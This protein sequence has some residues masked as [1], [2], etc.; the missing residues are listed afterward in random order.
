MFFSKKQYFRDTT[1]PAGI[2]ETLPFR[3]VPAPSGRF[4][5][6]RNPETL[7]IKNDYFGN[8]LL[9]IKDRNGVIRQISV[10]KGANKP[11]GIDGKVKWSMTPNKFRRG[12]GL[13]TDTSL[14]YQP[15]KRRDM[16][17]EFFKSRYQSAFEEALIEKKIRD[18]NKLGANKIKLLNDNNKKLQDRLDATLQSNKLAEDRLAQ[19]K[20]QHNQLLLAL[21]NTTTPSIIFSGDK[22][23][24][25]AGKIT[26]D[27]PLLELEDKKPE[28]EPAPE[29]SPEPAPEV[30][31]AQNTL[32]A[33][34]VAGLGE[35]DKKRAAAGLDKRY[36]SGGSEGGI[37]SGVGGLSMSP[38]AP[39]G[40]G[41]SVASTA[42]ESVLSSLTTAE[43]EK[44]VKKVDELESLSSGGTTP[45]KKLTKKQRKEIAELEKKIAN[46]PDKPEVFVAQG[47]KKVPNPLEPK[48]I[49]NPLIE[50]GGGIG[51]SFSALAEEIK[52]DESIKEFREKRQLHSIPE[53][54]T[55]MKES[56]FSNPVQLKFGEHAISAGHG[57]TGGM[58]KIMDFD[59]V[60]SR[61]EGVDT[62]KFKKT[63]HRN[64]AK[65]V[66]WRLD[67]Y[68]KLKDKPFMDVSLNK[69]GSFKSFTG[70]KKDGTFTEH[71][72]RANEITLP[73]TQE[74]ADAFGFDLEEHDRLHKETKDLGGSR[75]GRRKYKKGQIISYKGQSGKISK[76]LP[77]DPESEKLGV[78]DLQ[79]EL[80]DGRVVD[81]TDINL[82]ELD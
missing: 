28:P 45:R 3:N 50:G 31:P 5:N 25:D 52:E 4:I 82:D 80:D 22:G 81:T 77:P 44:I 61:F 64:D 53:L 16:T 6:V 71:P 65:K 75:A 39:K 29:V 13:K 54:H 27:K 69:D 60:K 76:V 41:A 8:E 56:K 15:P 9:T 79:I 32:G 58:G 73:P 59:D 20:L 34:I 55:K 62:S 35:Q 10:M 40:S 74:Y 1:L 72:L 49:K 48:P 66:E 12:R 18:S 17:T 36:V 63:K 21:S 43:A 7:S 14:F 26:G 51:S 19:D 33:A 37:T 46:D 42:E 2:T 70:K 57:K 67:N 23:A 11:R 68:D 38:S 30:S 24:A 47:D 78:V